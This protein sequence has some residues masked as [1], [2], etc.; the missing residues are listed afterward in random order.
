MKHLLLKSWLVM[1]CLMMGVGSAWGETIYSETFGSNTTSSTIA[2]TS[3]SS[4]F[5]DS[6]TSTYCTSTSWKISK[7]TSVVCDVTGTSGNS[8]LFSQTQNDKFVLVFGDLSAYTNVQLKVNWKNGAS[9]KNN[10]TLTIKASANGG[11]TYGSDLIGT[12]KSQNWQTLTYNIPEGSLSNFAIEFTNTSTN[13]SRIDD[14]VLTGT[15]VGGKVLSSIT[16]KTAPTKI[17]YMEGECFNPAGLVITKHFSNETTEDV[18]YNETTK[19][20]FTFSPSLTTELTNQTQVTITYSEK[21]INQSITVNPF[22]VTPG[23]YSINL[24]KDLYGLSAGNNDTEQSITKKGITIVS[25]C[26]SSAQTKTYYDGGHIRYYVDSY[27][28]LTAPIG[29]A[30]TNITFVEPSTGAKWDATETGGVSVN[31]GTYTH[32]TKTWSGLSTQVDFSFSKQCRIASISVTYVPTA[33]ITLNA[34]CND[35]KKVY[36]TYSN[37]SAWVVPANLTVSEVCVVDGELAIYSYNEGDVVPANAGVMVSATEGGNYTVKLTTETATASPSG[38]YNC[39]L[40]TSNDGITASNMQVSGAEF[41]RLTMHNGSTIGFWWGAEDGAAFN[42]GAN[43]AYLRVY[44]EDLGLDD[45]DPARLWFGND[46]ETA[47]KTVKT[48]SSKAFIYNLAGQRINKMQKGI[49]IVNGKK[50]IK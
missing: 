9:T 36:S 49:N 3:A 15:P 19:D 47:I 35:G 32:E 33:T 45:E 30:I 48:E 12:N 20:D 22:V 29:Y 11:S 6:N 31:S 44:K 14:I 1:L 24:N 18:E 43:K 10:R 25:G 2:W 4:Y 23:T 34:A 42:L 8:H 37:A 21:N 13:D 27:L 41:F 39:L 50:I 5:S 28:K 16:I 46:D 17:T 38:G 7:N 26:A 40:G